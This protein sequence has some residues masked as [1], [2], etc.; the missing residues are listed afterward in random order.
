MNNNDISIKIENLSCDLVNKL[1]NTLDEQFAK[2]LQQV[3]NLDDYSIKLS[4][5]ASFVVVVCDGEYV[6]MIAYYFNENKKEFYIPYL[7]VRSSHRKLGV[8]DLMMNKICFEADKKGYNISLEVRKDNV[9]AIKLYEKHGFKVSNESD[10]K[11][12]MIKHSSC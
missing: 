11:I 6:G 2:H 8:A 10:I 1:I 4:N 9:S 12:C 3:V 7:C 5:N